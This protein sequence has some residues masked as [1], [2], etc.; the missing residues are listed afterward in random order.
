MD[1]TKKTRG[2]WIVLVTRAADAGQGTGAGHGK[3]DLH[4]RAGTSC[5]DKQEKVT[6]EKEEG[7]WTFTLII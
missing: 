7:Y 3:C 1:N 6:D 4:P 2:A 5:P